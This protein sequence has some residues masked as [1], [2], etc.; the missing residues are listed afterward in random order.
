MFL[1][2][3]IFVLISS[4]KFG[5]GHFEPEPTIKYV[6][7]KG[8][9][10]DDPV[11]LVRLLR[12]AER[13]HQKAAEQM[14]VLRKL[15]EKQAAAEKGVSF[16]EEKG[17]TYML[18]TYLRDLMS[19]QEN[20]C[21]CN[22]TLIF[23]QEGL[24]S[25]FIG[26]SLG[27]QIMCNSLLESPITPVECSKMVDTVFQGAVSIAL[28]L[29]SADVFCNLVD[30]KCNA[31]TYNKTG[32]ISCAYCR[33]IH[34]KAKK[35]AEYFDGMFAGLKVMCARL[36]QPD[37]KEHCEDHVYVITN[38]IKQIIKF[39]LDE[40]EAKKLCKFIFMCKK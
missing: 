23:I 2:F 36:E 13:D 28:E 9:F 33:L 17:A 19:K 31:M 35:V 39:Y 24:R 38:G 3:L 25:S 21:L 37:V 30:K 7:D 5:N 22:G 29:S 15:I 34:A 26:G 11:E 32:P 27:M 40:K 14:S 18:N 6:T 12:Q 8:N 20:G 16:R 1:I 4:P 10:L